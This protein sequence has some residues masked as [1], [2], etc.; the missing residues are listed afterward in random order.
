MRQ[1]YKKDDYTG[2]VYNGIHSSQFG[3]FSVANGGRYSRGLSP[4]FND[5]T[6]SVPGQDG[7]H[8]FGTQMTQ[9]QI[10]VEIAFDSVTEAE[11]QELRAWLNC[12]IKPLIFDETPYIQYYAKIQTAPSI[13]FVPFE[14]DLYERIYKGECQITFVCYDPYGYSVSKWLDSY[15]VQN[16][17]GP[18]SVSYY[19]ENVREWGVASRLQPSQ[20][21]QYRIFDT[22]QQETDST[23]GMITLYNAGDLPADYI[24][25]FTITG[26]TESSDNEISILTTHDST[27]VGSYKLDFTKAQKLFKL[28]LTTEVSL[29]FSL[30]T[31]R[32]LLLASYADGI[33][34]KTLVANNCLRGEYSKIPISA[35]L[36]D[37][38]FMKISSSKPL[39]DVSIEYMYKYY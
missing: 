21:L 8:Y 34:I 10:Q 26:K 19:S 28:D 4:T 35:D 29:I 11:F 33:V 18:N 27:T 15:G 2:F 13:Q 22:Y 31:R 16:G 9:R 12:G 30:D 1:F 6:A 36:D 7:T 20:A 24:L 5:L 17:L 37:F 23:S 14:E 38:S 39:T 25:N 32:H 3:L